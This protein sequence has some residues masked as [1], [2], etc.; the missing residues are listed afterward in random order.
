[1]KIF[2][3]PF[4]GYSKVISKYQEKGNP[5]KECLY[6]N[7][8]DSYVYFSS[9][10]GFGRMK[11][12]FEGDERL[13]NF[14]VPI[15]KFLSIAEQYDTEIYL[16]SNLVFY[17]GKDKY[18]LAL[19]QDDNQIDCSIFENMQFENTLT[20]N[21]DELLLIE[22]AVA[23]TPKDLN[24]DKPLQAVFIKDSHICGMQ[25]KT[26][27]Y[28]SVFPVDADLIIPFSVANTILQIGNSDTCSYQFDSNNNFQRIISKKEDFEVLVSTNVSLDFPPFREANF[29]QS[30]ANGLSVTLDKY[31]FDG[32]LKLLKPHFSD[33]LNS[34]IAFS[35]SDE[36]M[37]I[38]VIDKDTNI[39]KHISY[40]TCDSDLA[41]KIFHISGEKVL[42]A[43]SKLNEKELTIKLPAQ[44]TNPIVEFFCKEDEHILITRF[45]D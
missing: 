40:I 42:Q 27:M 6:F 25:S 16:D 39:E 43:L 8:K 32:V 12:D 23:F 33:I 36:D 11:F 14:F 13:P 7:F 26:P 15:N 37:S 31:S 30:Y 38:I 20:L 22:N 3:T 1:M 4:V 10:D 18:K 45:R 9:K 35:F 2:T 19:I 24:I 17:Y 34:K 29:I 41:G 21:K 5:T 28:E 44:E